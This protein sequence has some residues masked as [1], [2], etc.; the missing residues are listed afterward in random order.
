MTGYGRSE[1][2]AGG[3]TVVAEIRSVNSRFFEIVTRLPRSLSVKENDIKELIR[4][5]VVRGKLNLTI[6][7]EHENEE[8]IPMRINSAAARAY[9]KLLSELREAVNI[10]EPVTLDHLLKFSEILE[11]QEIENSDVKEWE[12]AVQV[13]DA[14]LSNLVS[15]RLKEGEE[16]V[17]DLE[18]RLDSTAKLIEEINEDGGTRVN[19]ERMK[20]R[21]RIAQLLEDPS[22][23]DEG[24]LEL[25]VA[26]IADKLDVTEE[27]VRFRSHIKFFHETMKKEL[28]AGR[29]LGFLLQEMNREANTIGSKTSD[30]EIAHKVVT[31]KEE[32][33][34][35]RE[36]LQNIE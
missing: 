30:A 36:Q 23:I 2:S 20:I 31:I 4:K 32:L 16:L 29:K 19:E 26:I 11:I 25:E 7:I 15:M 33:E 6:S 17:R 9:H 18:M 1:L 3:M 22:V 34:K 13:L 14:A 27:C 35:I 21:E 8:E 24:R 10:K 28:G 5:K 12:L